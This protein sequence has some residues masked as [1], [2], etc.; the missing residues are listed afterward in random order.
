MLGPGA[1]DIRA[2]LDMLPRRGWT[3]EMIDQLP[4]P[5]HFEI[6]DGELLGVWPD[7]LEPESQEGR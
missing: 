6:I 1:F 3:A 7:E 5:F 4:Y 2:W